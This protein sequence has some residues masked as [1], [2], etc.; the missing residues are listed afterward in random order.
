MK[1]LRLKFFFSVLVVLFSLYVAIPTSFP[2]KFSL[3]G[4]SV[5]QVFTKSFLTQDLKLGLDLVG[6]SR[7]TYQAN[8]E[9]RTG[10]EREEA[11]EAL[12]RVIEK[13]V[14]LFGVSESSVLRSSFGGNERIVVELPGV[15]DLDSAKELVGKTAQLIFAEVKGENELSP[16]DL[17]GS[18]LK[19]ARVAY[20][21]V[22]GAPVISIEFN[23]EGSRKFEEITGR[24][25]GKP[26]PIVLDDQIVSA[27][28]VNE[29]IIGGK[30][31]ISGDFDVETAK[32]LS[33]Q[34]TAGALPVTITLVEERTVGASLGESAVI[35]S[36]TAGLIGLGIVGLFMVLV[37]RKL[38]IIACVGLVSFAVI[39]L[40]IYKLIPITLTVPGIAGFLLSVGMAVDSNILT[41]ERFKEEKSKGLPVSAAMEIA[42]GRAWDSIRDANIAT[43]IAAFILANPLDW[44][45]L[46]V[47]GPVRGFA[48]TLALGIFVSLFT[49][50]FMG[51]NMVRPFIKK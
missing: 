12:L 5:D 15:D 28:V 16:T 27:P 50:V 18:D 1:N 29:K 51:R 19:S 45:F 11:M 3:G 22:S 24:N 23:E 14:N 44:S 4:F 30:A 38:G 47:S 37:Y 6:G 40:A 39:S 17:T 42:F 13:R 7:L 31:Q 34:L 21:T 25:V 20:D 43:L 33:V 26:I 48:Y 41:F 46:N 49:G 10:A 32:S 9:D 2:V 35:A 36:V 8:I